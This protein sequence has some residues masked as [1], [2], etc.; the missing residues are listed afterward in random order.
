MKPDPE[1]LDPEQPGD[2]PKRNANSGMSRW[3]ILVLLG[4]V[5][6]GG[7]ALVLFGNDDGANEDGIESAAGGGAL[8][9]SDTDAEGVSELAGL[10]LPETSAEFLSAR[11]D[12]D[13]QLDVTFTIDPTD[14]AAFV[15]GS[16]FPEPVEGERVIFHSSPLWELNAQGP[17]RGTGDTVTSGKQGVRRSV[18]LIAEGELVRVR[19]VITPA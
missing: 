12:D 6:L 5:A 2:S 16:G 17:I 9:L 8:D 14:E 13:S 19:L 11:L 1:Q 4:V 18:E 15:E 10:A 7:L 3:W